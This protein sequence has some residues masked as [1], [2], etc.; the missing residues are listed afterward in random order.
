MLLIRK[1]FT[2]P[3]GG[4]GGS[5]PTIKGWK[6]LSFS[7]QSTQ[8]FD[9]TAFEDG[10]NTNITAAENDIV[11]VVF[12]TSANAAQSIS[13]DTTGYT[14]LNPGTTRYVND[15]SDV[16]VIAGYKRMGSTPDTTL[17][18]NPGSSGT[19]QQKT[20]VAVIIS[21][22]NTTTAAD[23]SGQI[24][25][26]ANTALID[27]PSVT[28]A[29]DNSLILALGALATANNSLTITGPANMDGYKAAD[30]TTN[31][32]TSMSMIAWYEQATAAAFNP[33]A[34]TFSA[35]S[36]STSYCWAGYTIVFKP[37]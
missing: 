23:D 27:C 34:I 24:A 7:A 32:K 20:A 29:Q 16:T 19:S 26:S 12:A 28:P 5:A 6:T 30:T 21:G 33:D 15:T 35:G 8:N 18:V 36:D 22:V 13:I 4:G 1:C 10:V 9:L 2:I 25:S 31:T 14:I 17:T 3:T 37:V 11:A